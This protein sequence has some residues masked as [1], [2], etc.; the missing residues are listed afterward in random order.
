MWPPFFF[1]GHPYIWHVTVH[2]AS[3]SCFYFQH[4]M[5]SPYTC[6]SHLNHFSTHRFN[7]HSWRS[8]GEA[9]FW[10][11]SAS[12]DNFQWLTVGKYVQRVPLNDMYLFEWAWVSP[13]YYVIA[14]AAEQKYDRGG[15][16]LCER[17]R[18]SRLSVWSVHVRRSKIGGVKAPL[19]LPVPPPLCDCDLVYLPIFILNTYIVA[20]CLGRTNACC[21]A[22]K[23]V[24]IRQLTFE[25]WCM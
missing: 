9:W 18:S 14:V 4:W 21:M 2:T 13:T 22:S 5:L 1:S 16:G 20:S 6:P 15:G 11:I 24:H 23:T 12:C 3:G 8:S 10:F 7:L 19:A 17:L 25:Q